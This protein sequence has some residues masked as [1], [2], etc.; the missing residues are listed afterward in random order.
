ML[1]NTQMQQPAHAVTVVGARAGIATKE[2]TEQRMREFRKEK[3][4]LEK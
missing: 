1:R 3:E 2:E 4:A